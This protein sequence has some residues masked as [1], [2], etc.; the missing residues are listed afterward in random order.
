[1]LR[2]MIGESCIPRKLK[3]LRVGVGGSVCICVP[4]GTFYSKMGTNYVL[5]NGAGH[6]SR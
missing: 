3:G 4:L 5:S 6:S 2:Y 1:M